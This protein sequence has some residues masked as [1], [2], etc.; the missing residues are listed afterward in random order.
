[1]VSIIC[2]TILTVLVISLILYM[3]Y[4]VVLTGNVFLFPAHQARK[5]QM[6]D[7][8]EREALLLAEGKQVRLD[9][10]IRYCVHTFH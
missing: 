5:Q 4:Q 6:S 3:T 8:H 9:G 7:V 2:T 10:D 1:M